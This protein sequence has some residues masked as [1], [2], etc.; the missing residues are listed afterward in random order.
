MQ[1][2][3]A[4]HATTP[5]ILARRTFEPGPLHVLVDKRK[6]V[7]D[8]VLKRLFRE[9]AER[10]R[11][12]HRRVV[13]HGRQRQVRRRVPKRRELPVEHGVDGAAVGA[14]DHVVDTQVAVDERGDVV[15]GER[16]G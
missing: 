4:S 6:L 14:E 11:Q 15:G 12:R 5:R 3:E 2:G 10:R 9:P 7:R 1:C 13:R 8:A 16:L